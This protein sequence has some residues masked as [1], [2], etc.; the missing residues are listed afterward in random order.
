VKT[1]LLIPF[2]FIAVLALIAG[3]GKEPTACFTFSSSS[4]DDNNVTLAGE[5]VAFDNCSENATDYS[6]DFGDNNDDTGEKTT[7]A[8]DEAGTYT[9]TMTA[10]GDGG[11]KSTSQDVEVAD[12][13]DTWTGILTLDTDEYPIILEIEQKGV[14]LTGTFQFDDGS[15]LA[16]F[17]SG[18]ETDV[19]D[20]TIKFT[21]PDATYPLP[22]K[23]IGTINDDVDAMEGTYTITG[24]TAGGDWS[25]TR[26]SKKSTVN[27]DGKGLESFRKKLQ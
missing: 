6:W 22:F 16:D 4:I 13:T 20:V 17:T 18:S 21:V 10:T 7:H 14:E 11:S 15:G 3:C 12:L 24:Y 19:R 2:A 5:D 1:K 25:V 9:V 26:G 23:F 8:Y 27:P